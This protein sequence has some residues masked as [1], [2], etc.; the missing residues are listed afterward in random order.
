MDDADPS[1][2]G[3][4]PLVELGAGVAPTVYGKAEWFNFG[5]A[6]HG[7][8]SVKARV[9]KSM[10]D[11]AAARGELDDGRTIIEASSGNTGAAVARVG[12]ARGHDVEIVLP[13]DAGRGKVDAIRDAGA[14]LRFVD[15]DAGYDAFVEECRRLVDDHPDEY[16]YPNQ[17][18]NP[19]NPAVHAGT[20][21]PEIWDQTAGEVTH[22]VAG[23]G[24]GGTLV[25]VSHALR[26][27]GV[28]VHGYEPP[29]KDHD[30]A[31]LKHMH[32]PST[33]VP[34]TF[35]ADALDAREYVETATAYEWVRR[36]RRRHESATIPIRDAGQWSRE[37][38]RSELRV[39]GEFL[40]GPS[41]GGALALVERLAARGTLDA[42]DVVVVP[43]PDRGDRYPDREP[44][45]DYD[46]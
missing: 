44:Y 35:E 25:G 20:T 9:G 39:G 11:A 33:F 37:F 32:D 2:V 21:G 7:G 29:A 22:F 4:T 10:L 5:T 38:V 16:V 14:E 45:V 27:R 36:L 15:A 28:H 1:E 40:V 18:A 23:A 3:R 12:A 8:G 6:G 30:V 43:L 19:A 46:E 17:Y 34:E 26:P 13:D 41:T 31:G 42:E 24:T